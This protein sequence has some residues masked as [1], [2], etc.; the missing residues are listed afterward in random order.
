MFLDGRKNSLSL[1]F[2]GFKLFLGLF[3]GWAVFVLVTA[4]PVALWEERILKRRR[5][6]NGSAIN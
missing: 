5:P 1:H 2:V 3:M 4:I 6:G